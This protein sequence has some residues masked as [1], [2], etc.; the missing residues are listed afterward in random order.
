MNEDVEH[1]RAVQ[2][3]RE[4]VRQVVA[5]EYPLSSTEKVAVALVLDGV[6]WMLSWGTILERAD[7]IGPTWLSAALYV[8]RNGWEDE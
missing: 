8:Q 1:V 3:I 5:H 6:D 7:Y 2:H 4:K